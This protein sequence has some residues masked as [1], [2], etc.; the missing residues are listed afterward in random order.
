MMTT[1]EEFLILCKNIKS[2]R[3]RNGLSKKKMAELMG[4]SISS[5]TKLEQG[6]MP[7]RIK[8]DIIFNLSVNFDIHPK[9]LFSPL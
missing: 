6:F 4:I 2:L 1:N 7:H 8:V 5:L 9:N 3:E